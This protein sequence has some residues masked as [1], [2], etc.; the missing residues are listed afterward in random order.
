[1]DRKSRA[2]FFYPRKTQLKYL[3]ISKCWNFVQQERL[4]LAW[5]VRFLVDARMFTLSE[6]DARYDDTRVRDVFPRGK[7]RP[8]TKPGSDENGWTLRYIVACTARD[9]NVMLLQE[10]C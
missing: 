2:R 7:K 3:E 5:S 10:W 1:M 8:A 4:R 6:R 9:R